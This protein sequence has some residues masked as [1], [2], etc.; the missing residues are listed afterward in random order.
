[1]KIP[2]FSLEVACPG[3]VQ[4]QE[5]L[6][7]MGKKIKFI[8]T[9][10]SISP[11]TA[12]PNT[13]LILSPSSLEGKTRV[14]YTSSVP[15]FPRVSKGTIFC[16]HIYNEWAW[17]CLNAW[18]ILRTN[19]SGCSLLWSAGLDTIMKAWTNQDFSL[20]VKE[21]SAG[22]FQ[23]SSYFNNFPSNWCVLAWM[24]SWWTSTICMTWWLQRIRES[25]VTCC[26]RKRKLATHITDT[27]ES[28][29]QK[30]PKKKPASLL[31]L[32]FS[33]SVLSDSLWPQGL[34][35]PRLP[36]PSSS[37]GACSDSCPVSQWCHPSISSSVIPFSSCLQSLPA[38]GPFPMSWLS[39]PDGQ[40]LELQLQHQSFQWVF[41]VDF[42]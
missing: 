17:H 24:G 29:K 6:Q 21:R 18:E 42:L 2:E 23:H 5:Q 25:G 28:K 7:E 32:F 3:W 31:L 12:Q 36:C 15:A 16:S 10:I 27:R 13:G 4:R 39:A 38:S 1:M 40:I 30:P 26:G 22:S 11:N 35:H 20:K 37:P 14:E 41:T 19:R 9:S 8:L 33:C 34:Q